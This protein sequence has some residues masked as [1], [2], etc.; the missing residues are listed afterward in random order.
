M[1]KPEKTTCSISRAD[2]KAKAQPLAIKIGDATIVGQVKEFST[3]SFGWYSND[4]VTVM[5][6]GKP[7]VAQVGLNLIAVGSKEAA[8]E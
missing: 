1:A 7:V 4:K 2:F 3:G 5:V 8:K 6:D